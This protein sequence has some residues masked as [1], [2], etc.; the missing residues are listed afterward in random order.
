MP[1]AKVGVAPG[2]LPPQADKRPAA[3]LC[4]LF[5]GEDEV[6][7]AEGGVPGAEGGACLE[8]GETCVVLTRRAAH[9]SSHAGEVSFPGGRL[10]P[11]E[12]PVAAALREAYEEIG[13]A[14]G[15]V[16][17]IGELSPLTT[18]NSPAFVYCFVGTFPGP[19]P[20]GSGLRIDPEEVERVF[21]VPLS[22]LAAD[23]VFH[24]E[25]WPG[26]DGDPGAGMGPRYRAI[27]FFILGD[28]IVWGATGRMLFELL[29]VVLSRRDAGG[30]PEGTLVGK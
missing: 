22:R 27:P 11:G 30:S 16:E 17:V 19:G 26:A 15:D 12:L 28:D 8:A 3:V 1:A 4:L 23:G 2:E 14:V 10:S 7:G 21:W 24:E 25:L 29:N 6:P 13:V 20:G 5:E 9:L 18:R